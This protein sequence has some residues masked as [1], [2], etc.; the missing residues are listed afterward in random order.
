MFLLFVHICSA[1]LAAIILTAVT[2]LFRYKEF[3]KLWH[4]RNWGNMFTFVVCFFVTA[5]VGA[6]EGTLWLCC[7]CDSQGCR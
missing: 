7:A 3:M 6:V 4:E 5:F 1:S 2:G